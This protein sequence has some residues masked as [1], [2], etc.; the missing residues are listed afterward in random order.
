[1]VECITLPY[2]ADNTYYFDVLYNRTMAVLLDSC[3]AQGSSGRYDIMSAQPYCTLTHWGDH[4]DV[5]LDN[6]TYQRYDDPFS[7][8]QEYLQPKTPTVDNLPFC[9]GALGFFGYELAWRLENFPSMNANEWRAPEMV[10]GLYDWALIVDHHLKKST[11]VAQHRHHETK[12]R[13]TQLVSLWK[14][15]AT[16]NTIKPQHVTLQPDI[17][18]DTYEKAFNTIKK[19]IYAGDCYQANLSQRFTGSFNGNSWSLYQQIRQQNP[20]PFAAYL[21]YDDFTVLSISPEKFITV[22]DDQV[23]TQPIK[24]TRPSHPKG[25]HVYRPEARRRIRPARSIS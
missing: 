17:S 19:H 20:A 22:R 16:K 13:I 5:K 18:K 14:T 2:Y 11:L 3:H 21:N 24:G 15:P 23:I 6:K 10:M 1:M 9:G 12:G 25:N 4:T 8:M 7:L